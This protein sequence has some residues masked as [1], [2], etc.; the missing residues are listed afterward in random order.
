M[1]LEGVVYPYLETDKRDLHGED[2][3]QAVDSAVSHINAVG[4]SASEHQDKH[5]EGDQVD[6]EHVATPG[7]NLHTT[8]AHLI[9]TSEHI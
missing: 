7:G 4:E 1:R 5:M 2:G 3:S 9:K 6:Q 8:H